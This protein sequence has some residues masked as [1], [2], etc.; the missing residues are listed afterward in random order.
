M[1]LFKETIRMSCIT[2]LHS[3]RWLKENNL[4]LV[5]GVLNIRKPFSYVTIVKEYFNNRC[6]YIK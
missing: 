4:P 1:K 5:K 2:I 3:D 6:M